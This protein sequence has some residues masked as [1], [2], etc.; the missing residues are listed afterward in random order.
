MSEAYESLG[1]FERLMQYV[2]FAIDRSN[3]EIVKHICDDKEDFLQRT[4]AI[5]KAFSKNGRIRGKE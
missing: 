2:A 4:P 5:L 3:S 1:T